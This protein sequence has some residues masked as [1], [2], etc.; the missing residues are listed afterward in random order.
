MIND[1]DARFQ[2]VWTM[3]MKIDG[4]IFLRLS[5]DKIKVIK[6]LEICLGIRRWPSSRQLLILNHFPVPD[7]R[8]LWR[9]TLCWGMVAKKYIYVILEYGYDDLCTCY[10][11]GLYVR[12]SIFTSTTTNIDLYQ[13]S[14]MTSVYIYHCNHSPE[15]SG[16]RDEQTR[17]LAIFIPK[18]TSKGSILS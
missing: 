17:R 5:C 6:P 11:F 16:S 14:M 4:C 15:G 12:R 3:D 7:S 1:C 10:V 9:L 8:W 2:K 13:S 18:L